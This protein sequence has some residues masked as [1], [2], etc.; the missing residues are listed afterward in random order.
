MRR[1]RCFSIRA[2]LGLGKTSITCAA[3][4]TLKN[5]KAFKGALVIAP[6]RPVY[7]VWPK[8]VEKWLEFKDFSVGILHG[9][10]KED[11]LNEE[12][13]IYVMNYEG[14]DW[15]FGSPPPDYKRMDATDKVYAKQKYEAEQKIARERLKTLFSKVDTLVFDELSK[16]KNPTSKRFKSIKPYLGKFAR[17][18]GLTGSPASNGLMDLFGQA[19]V[20]DKGRAL[21]E[22]ITHYRTK[23]FVPSGF[24]GFDWK[25]QSGAEDKIYAAM[26]PLALRM[27]AEDYLEMPKI[28]PVTIKVALPPA[29]RKMYDQMEE[30]MFSVMDSDEFVAVNAA[31]ASTKC[32]QIAN[33]ALYKD[34]ID[35]LTGIPA[36][37]K[38]EWKEVHNAKLQALVEL[39]EELQGQ[40][41]LGGY[42]FGHDL[43]RIVK[44][45]GKDTPHC[46]KNPK[47]VDK[48]F[49]RWNNNELPYLFGHPA[50]MGHGNNLQEGDACHIAWF[51]IPWDFELYDQMVRR[52]RRQGNKA[53]TIFV[54]HFVAED[55]VDEAKMA[56]LHNK[57][58]GQK[59]FL[60]ALRAY[61]K[62]KL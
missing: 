46:D 21:G 36:T 53:K 6:L 1:L 50:S 42:H 47:E 45:L 62:G 7:S 20:L 59:A 51:S 14:I 15:L 11:V 18:W 12:H 37:G 32:A 58:K 13:D 23:Y 33:G 17:R 54:Y 48:L 55:T 29:A 38:R 49:S 25:L 61:R 5:K 44:T 10:N 30:E 26:R 56:A 57:N 24:G 60:D 4:K 22:Y 40:P 19:Y 34:R 52:L 9:D 41:L 8:E 27:D 28:V 3:F 35:P 39:I 16:M 31:S 2:K 43:E